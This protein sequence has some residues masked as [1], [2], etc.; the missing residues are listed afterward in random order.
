[1]INLCISIIVW[2]WYICFCSA[3]RLKYCFIN[4]VL[5]FSRCL[6]IMQSIFALTTT[7][8]VTREFLLPIKFHLKGIFQHQIFYNLKLGNNFKFCVLHANII[9]MLSLQTTIK[10]TFFQTVTAAQLI[11]EFL[12]FLWGK[13]YKLKFELYPN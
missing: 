2:N 6:E 4:Y 3:Y 8:R 9:T 12:C 13:K 11:F 7:I 1:M 10:A 5:G